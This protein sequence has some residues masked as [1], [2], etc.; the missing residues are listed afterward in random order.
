MKTRAAFLPLAALA[1]LFLGSMPNARAIGVQVPSGAVVEL[2]SLTGVVSH[3]NLDKL[4]FTLTWQHRGLLK[5]EHY[6]PSYQQNYRVTDAT[7]YKNGAWTMMQNGA[8]VRISGR[9]FVASAV[10]FLGP[11]TQAHAAAGAP[12]RKLNAEVFSN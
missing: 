5:M 12:R 1:V 6:Y 7:V 2:G 11:S 4:T 8:R 9:S 3:V 10:E